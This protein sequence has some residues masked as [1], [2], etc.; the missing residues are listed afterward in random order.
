M[1]RSLFLVLLA[2][3]PLL[4][5]MTGF[6]F[7]STADVPQTTLSRRLGELAHNAP[8]CVGHRGAAQDYPENTLPSFM[9]AV[10]VG[11]DM[12]ELDFHQ[13]SDGILI[14]M[15][16]ATL[17]R[18]TDIV[19]R[20][21]EQEV[22]L[23]TLPAAQ[24]LALDAGSWKDPR[25]AGTPPPT[26]DQALDVIQANS[27]TMIEHKSGEPG[28]LVELLR[29]KNLLDDVLVQSFDWDFLE[30]VHLL[31]PR[32]TIG[33]LGSKELTGERLED[34]RRTGASMV[35]WNGNDLAADTISRLRRRGY[36]VCIYTVNEDEDFLRAHAS[37]VDAI[38]TDRPARLMELIKQ[39]KLRR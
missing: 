4:S 3:T 18:T 24:T 6:G 26:L 19:Q 13:S 9:A 31:E 29:S 20:L 22:R 21:E 15:H 38:T 10:A 25:F 16:D 12:V 14:C 1:H 37:G 7:D 35:H 32:L 33:A 17:D 34:L 2:H 27:I 30:A 11:A 8:L 5:C 28:K 39:G 36:L 23:A